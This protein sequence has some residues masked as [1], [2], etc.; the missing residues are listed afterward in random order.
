M[1]NLDVYKVVFNGAPYV[2]AAYALIWAS[3]AVFVG[4]IFNRLSKL[5]KELAVVEDAVERRRA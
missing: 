1:S 3:L 5:E 2:I 4:L